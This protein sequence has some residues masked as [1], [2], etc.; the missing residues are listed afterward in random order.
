V[1]LSPHE[2]LLVTLQE[3]GLD[4]NE[5]KK[6][7]HDKIL[8]ENYEALLDHYIKSTR[9]SEQLYNELVKKDMLM[10]ELLEELKRINLI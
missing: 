4:I 1:E 9:F 5:M 8:I 10:G 3:R 6:S 2:E 7:G